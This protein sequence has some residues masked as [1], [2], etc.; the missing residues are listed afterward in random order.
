ME[1][2]ENLSRRMVE[3]TAD[4]KYMNP[5]KLADVIGV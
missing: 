1:N 2:I 4:D 3:E 5:R